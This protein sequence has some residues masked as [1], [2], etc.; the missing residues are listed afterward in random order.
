M[1]VYVS[2]TYKPVV[3]ATDGIARRV[4]W[5][6]RVPCWVRRF[7]YSH[8]PTGERCS[9]VLEHINGIIRVKEFVGQAMVHE[10]GG[11]FLA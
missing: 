4:L 9:F 5:S 2:I 3:A 8:K 7:T 10:V 6:A 11:W 1:T